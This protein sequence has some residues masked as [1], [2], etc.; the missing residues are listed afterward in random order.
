MSRPFLPELSSPWTAPAICYGP[1]R[2]GQHPGG[3]SPS[4]AEL[5]EDLT[6]LAR[7]WKLVRLYG[8]VGPCEALLR[9]IAEE[10]VPL[11]VLLGAWIAPESS[12][13][14]AGHVVPDP[15]AIAANRREIETAIRLANAYPEI[16]VGVSV[17]N[18]T[19]VF[20]SAHRSPEEQLVSYLREVRAHTAVPIT[21]ADDWNFW[22]LPESAA[23]ANEIDFLLVHAHPLWNGIQLDAALDWTSARLAEIRATHPGRRIVLG[24]IGWATGRHT[25]GEQARLIKGATGEAEQAEFIHALSA[26]IPREQV[27]TFVFEAFDENWKGG[28][29]PDEVEKHWGLYHTNR[30]PKPALSGKR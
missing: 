16:V 1:H 22:R 29:H 13:G 12:A 15:E 2:D 27:V 24:E 3:A 5:R 18:E 8:A 25:E 30:Q 14:D 20:W 4:E 6:I 19:Q 10:Q 7:H 28:P 11:Q 26:W 17:G 9:L 23:I 21:T